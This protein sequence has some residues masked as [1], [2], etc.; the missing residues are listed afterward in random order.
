MV[1]TLQQDGY[2]NAT[3]NDIRI[4]KKK[5]SPGSP[6]DLEV[7]NEGAASAGQFTVITPTI[8]Q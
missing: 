8:F 6:V 1:R 4:L 3:I 7:I 2:P 5:G